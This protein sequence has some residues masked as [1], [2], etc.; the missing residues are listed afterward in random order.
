M[1]ETAEQ[2]ALLSKFVVAQIVAQNL[3]RL[4]ENR[5]AAELYFRRDILPALE[6]DLDDLKIFSDHQNNVQISDFL[7]EWIPKYHQ[8]AKL[9]VEDVLAVASWHSNRDNN[10]LND[11]LSINAWKDQDLAV[12]CLSFCL[13]STPG[14]VLTGIR[15]EAHVSKAVQAMSCGIIP[16]NQIDA[17]VSS[18][19]FE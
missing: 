2:L 19:F 8:E 13:S 15:Q 17:I 18:P 12:N 3:S 14:S 16:T 4:V 11:V 5:M 10:Q 1:G 9:L 7:E 6:K